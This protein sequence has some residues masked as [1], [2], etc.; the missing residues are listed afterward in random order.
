MLTDPWFYVIAV[1]AVLVTAISKGGLGGGLGVLAVP[2]M[3]LVIEPLTA[4]A[5]MLPI[6]CTI[7]LFSVRAFRWQWDWG[8]LRILLPAALAGIAL[9]TAT[10]HYFDTT[11]IKL[12][13][14]LVALWFAIDFVLA[15]A[16]RRSATVRAPRP[17]FGAFMGAIAGFTSFV[18]HAG[19]PPV[20]LYLLSQRLDKT[21]FVATTICFFAVVNFTKLIPYAWLGQFHR[22]TLLTA[23]VLAPLAPIGVWIGTW[24]HHRISPGLFYL[25][26]YGLLGLTGV[27]LLFDVAVAAL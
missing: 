1:P 12:L 17:L 14:G 16:R 4:A 6:L 19:S 9:A 20:N 22:E 13:V 11:L 21:V 27:K 3:A 10:A 25:L 24:L 26:C 15:R 18:A 2:L 7:D 5:I 23:L 8:N